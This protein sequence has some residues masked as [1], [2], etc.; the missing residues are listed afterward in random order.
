MTTGKTIALTRWTFLD[1]VKPLFFN[2]N[3]IIN[4]NQLSTIIN[5]NYSSRL[6]ISFLPRTER[7]L[8]S[9]LQSPSAAI[10]EPRNIK[11]SSVFT[12]SPPICH[13]VVASDAVILVFWMWSIKPTYSLSHFTFI[14]RLFSSSISAIRLVSSAYL[15]LLVFL[16][17]SSFHLEIPPAQLFSLCSL[18]RS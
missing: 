3:I 17:Q 15:R 10:L 11:S 13:E 1:K 16:R 6:L 4:N 9:W 5:N 7:L 2:I 14:K 18:C 8:T 12:V